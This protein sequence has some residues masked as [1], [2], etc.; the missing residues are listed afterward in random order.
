M[1]MNIVYNKKEK[2]TFRIGSRISPLALRQVDEVIKV[3]KGFYSEIEYKI[4]G[5]ETYGDKDKVTPISEIEKSDFFTRE[6]DEALLKGEIDFAVHSAKDLPDKIPEGLII[7]AI[8]KPLDPSDALIS[9][10]N[11]TIDKLPFG[12]KIAASSL[13]R[14][15]QLKKYRNDFQIVDI[16]GNINERLKKL[17]KGIS[18]GE[19]P[20]RG[21]LDAIIVATCALVRLG[22]E[23]RIT[24]RIPLDI[25]TP[26]PLQGSLA[27]ETKK[28][29][30][31]LIDMLKVLNFSA[32]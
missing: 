20:D 9:K 14:K 10:N 16:R 6:I 32:Y 24:Q 22:L 28:D 12:A 27:I 23:N 31:K 2:Y 30:K 4:I 18:T 17:D 25:L 8:T 19:S 3:L 7:A 13:R 15:I 11:L 26:H 1:N 5:I 29:N 21:E